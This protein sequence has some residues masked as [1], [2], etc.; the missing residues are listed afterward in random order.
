M[1][2]LKATKENIRIAAEMIKEGKLVAIPCD[3]LYGIVTNAFNEE[4]V[5]RIYNSKVR[6]AGKPLGIFINKE[7]ADKYAFINEKGRKILDQAMPCALQIVLKKKDIIPDYLTSSLD[8]VMLMCHESMILR[9]I[10]DYIK[11]PMT[12]SSLNYSGEK[13][14]TS[15]E[16]ALKYE[17]LVDL[18]LD[19]GT[20]K[21]GINGTVLDLTEEPR[22]LRKGAYSAEEVRNILPDLIE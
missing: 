15:F 14:A 12:G 10:Y 17:G 11:I 21:H 19:G 20:T 16:E 7:D 1:T 2:V 6:E 5:Q 13:P 4:S 18:I 8:T 3:T 9:E 22:I